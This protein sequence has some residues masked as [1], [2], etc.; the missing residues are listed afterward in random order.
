[1]FKEKS[2]FA[3]IRH[4][5]RIQISLQLKF[6]KSISSRECNKRLALNQRRVTRAHAVTSTCWGQSNQIPTFG[7]EIHPFVW[8]YNRWRL[9]CDWITSYVTLDKTKARKSALEALEPRRACCSEPTLTLNSVK[10]RDFYFHL[11]TFSGFFSAEPRWEGLQRIF[12]LWPF[13][14]F[15]LMFSQLQ[16]CLARMSILIQHILHSNYH[17]CISRASL[18]SVGRVVKFVKPALFAYFSLKIRQNVRA[19]FRT[20]RQSDGRWPH[21]ANR[22]SKKFLSII[23]FL[24]SV[25]Y[26]LLPFALF[27][28]KL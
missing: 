26:F 18:S 27:L 10:G 17:C 2:N 14:A 19:C 16:V 25:C 6:I 15:C 9:G 1:M 23:F 7:P 24:C 22:C 5:H 4:F 28:T 3:P 13:V 11:V 8:V 12:C 21:V 20:T